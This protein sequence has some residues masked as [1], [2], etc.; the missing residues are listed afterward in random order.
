ML[1]STT[2]LGDT[3]RSLICDVHGDRIIS[4]VEQDVEPILKANKEI[5]DSG[6]YK[7]AA[8][9][10]HHVASIPAVVYEDWWNNQGLKNLK[11]EEAILF[12]T[13]K[14]NDPEFALLRTSPGK[15]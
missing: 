1:K 7:K 2:I 10:M 14:L 13:R 8:G 12:I 15:M 4:T 11:G 6:S 3:K 9:N 5:R